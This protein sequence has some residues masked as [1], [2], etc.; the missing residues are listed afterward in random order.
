MDVVVF[1]PRERDLHVSLPAANGQVRRYRIAGASPAQK[2]ESEAAYERGPPGSCGSHDDQA[3]E[4][5]AVKD[6]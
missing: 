1:G 3:A 2:L 6:R 5:G 4:R